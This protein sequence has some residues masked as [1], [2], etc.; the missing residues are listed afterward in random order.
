MC[1]R[2][3]INLP[4]ELLYEIFD[5]AEAPQIVPRYNVAPTQ[6]APVIRQGVDGRNRLELLRWGLIPSW[7]K[8]QSI[9]SKLINARAET[10]AEKP[11]F[12]HALRSRRCVV[13]TSGFYEWQKLGTMRQPLHIHPK[14]G[15]LLPMAG[16]YDCWNN[17][18]TILET[19][20]ILTTE[21]NELI[22]PFHDRMPVILSQSGWTRWLDRSLTNASML[23]DLFSPY[24]SSLL[25][26]HP[27]S[28]LV[29]SMSHD[30]PDCI[31]PL[32]TD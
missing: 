32:V 25:V 29:N 13:V 19:F 8:D 16:L 31:E 10:A 5:L 30:S 7:A 23:K 3:T 1:G 12:K 21:A 15:S 24:P 26:M 4:P 28:K 17:D 9:D 11:S 2:Y 22:R 20:T 27:V 14:E 6:S 18:G